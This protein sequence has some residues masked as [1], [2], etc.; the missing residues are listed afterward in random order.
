MSRRLWAAA[1][2]AV[3]MAGACSQR[4]PASHTR[5]S[6]SPG[7]IVY[8][9]LG[10]S[11]TVGIGTQEPARQSFPQI[12]YQRLPRSAVLYNLGLPGETTEAALND[13]LPQALAVKPTLATVWFNVDDLA[14]G[15][16]VADY[17]ARLDRLVEALRRGG[18]GQVLVANTPRLE[19]LPAYAA[20]GP[21]P[22]PNVKCPLGSV[23]LPSPQELDALVAA[24]NAAVARVAARRGAV[25]V[26]LFAQGLVLNQHPEYV[27]SDGFHP[28]AQGA[29]AIAA[30][31]AQ[32]VQL[33][34]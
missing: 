33:T 9:A 6:A 12:L 22:P 2:L 26:D 14:A 15:V 20:C 3:M 32:Q 30:L 5:P 8:T 13:E 23:T 21:M 10:A 4:P 16:A 31:F 28:S 1:V 19:Q 27:S 25:V 11:E 24:Y 29:A 7:P 18:A 34:G 17:E